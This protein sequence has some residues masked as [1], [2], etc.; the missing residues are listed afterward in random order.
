MTRSELLLD[1]ATKC[2]DKCYCYAECVKITG[3]CDDNEAA[4]EMQCYNCRCR[5][6]WEPTNDK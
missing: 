2:Q 5:E 1:V 6:E 4:V 3:R